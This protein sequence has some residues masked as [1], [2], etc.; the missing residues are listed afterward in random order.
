MK[1]LLKVSLMTVLIAFCAAFTGCQKDGVGDFSLSVKEVGADYV[2]L[3]VTAPYAVQMY[4]ILSQEPTLVSDAVLQKTGVAVDVEPGQLLRID[5]DVVQ[6]THYHL[7]A[8]AVLGEVGYS[9]R[10]ELEFTTKKYHRI[11]APGES[12]TTSYSAKVIG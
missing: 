5:K 2:D 7:Y 9:G 12:F 4:Y 1:N 6:D 11:L 8:V 3:Y 10:I